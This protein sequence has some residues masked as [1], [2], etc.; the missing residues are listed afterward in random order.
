MSD[1]SE[2]IAAALKSEVVTVAEVE[3]LLGEVQGEIASLL[4]T[5]S[6]AEAKALDPLELPGNAEEFQM[7][8]SVM[9]WAARRSEAAA[10]ALAKKRVEAL[11]RADEDERRNV[12]DA[13]SRA[14]QDLDKRMQHCVKMAA[15]MRATFDDA[16]S[17]M[18]AVELINGELPQGAEPLMV[19]PAVA[20]LRDVPE[21]IMSEQV[22]HL[23]VHTK[24]GA[25]VPRA[26]LIYTNEFAPSRGTFA[27]VKQVEEHFGLG[28]KLA[29][30]DRGAEL[31]VYVER[32]VT[33]VVPAHS[34]NWFDPERSPAAV[35]RLSDA[36][37]APVVASKE[38]P[39]AVH[40]STHDAAGRRAAHEAREANRL[41]GS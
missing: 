17:V 11:H 30:R 39:T 4:N 22:E 1:L 2:R 21:R 6:A 18:E 5:A 19:P 28:H 7:E 32:L 31:A 34:Y 33:V 36:P 26:Q 29:I 23:W 16:I 13:T 24:T 8:H 20:L 40:E 27:S 38:A 9:S 15:N 35:R 3:A 14:L 41:R 37:P 25:E 10:T 12:Y